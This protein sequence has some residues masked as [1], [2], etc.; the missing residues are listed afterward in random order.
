MNGA[1]TGTRPVRVLHLRDSPW[2]DGPG[3][4]ILESA[5]RFDKRRVEYR[6]AVLVG[7]PGTEHPMIVEARSR[8][9]AIHAIEDRGGIDTRIVAGIT[10]LIDQF[11]IEILHASDVRTSIYC[12]VAHWL[13]PRVALVRTTHGWIANTFRRRAMRLLDKSL[14]RFF[15]HVT[16]VSSAMRELVPRWWLPDSRVTVVH[17][18]LPLDT[19]GR[20][21]GN[22][23]RLAPDPAV[24]VIVLN[25]GR[26][27]PEKG[28]DL[29]IRAVARLTT[30]YP[31]LHLRFAGIGGMEAELKALTNEL[32]ISERVEFLGY[33]QDMPCLYAEADLIVQSSLT[34]GLPNVI[35]EAAFLGI[36]VLA[37][38][39]G[40]TREVIEHGHGGW[41]VRPGSVDEIFEGL[42]QYLIDPGCYLRMTQVARRCVQEK[43]S[44]ETR[45]EKM[46]CLYERIAWR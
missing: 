17:N 7:H 45:M 23:D 1:T 27:S 2:V 5:E 41:L 33:V 24:R 18:A 38:D 36:P 39:V 20:A 28:Q 8:D 35:L 9:I 3:R 10:S 19:Y 37:T 44:F 25:V 16:L 22:V 34:E 40:G 14:L 32:G 26:L 13:R 30:E 21:Y 43:F 11:D 46:M 42:R 12:I 29:L 6:T 15:D 31:G 4:T